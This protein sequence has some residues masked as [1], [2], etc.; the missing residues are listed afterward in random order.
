M[1]GFVVDDEDVLLAADFAAQN[2]VDQRRIALDVA[3]GLD[4][5]LVEIALPVAILVKHSQQ[6]CCDLPL[7]L[8][9][10]EISPAAH[11]G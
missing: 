9:E 4:L 2:T 5:D 7:Q 10:R 8:G 1:V 6:A 11:A 3:H